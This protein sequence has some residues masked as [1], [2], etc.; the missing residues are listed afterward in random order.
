MDNNRHLTTGPIKWDEEAIK[1][2]R[3]QMPSHILM[4]YAPYLLPG[5]GLLGAGMVKGGKGLLG[6]L[7]DPRLEWMFR[8]GLIK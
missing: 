7:R 2:A 4:Q 3:E 6:L 1:K 5:M 8:Q